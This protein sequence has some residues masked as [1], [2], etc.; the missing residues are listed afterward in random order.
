MKAEGITVCYS[1]LISRKYIGIS[2][3]HMSFVF[4]KI[5]VKLIITYLNYCPTG[6][7]LIPLRSCCRVVSLS[8][9]KLSLEFVLCMIGNDGEEHFN[10]VWAGK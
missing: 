9:I 2:D 7:C 6:L 10:K 5:R 4:L 1:P 8:L 3:Y